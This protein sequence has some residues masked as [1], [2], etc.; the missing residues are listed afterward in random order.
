MI[1]EIRKR[2]NEKE[3]YSIEG[4]VKT[5]KELTNEKFR[6][7]KSYIKNL[8]IA[9]RDNP[10]D[11]TFEEIQF[12]RQINNKNKKGFNENKV[13]LVYK[14][15][16]VMLSRDTVASEILNKMPY[17]IRG[18]VDKLG[19]SINKQGCILYDDNRPIQTISDIMDFL[20][21]SRKIWNK[22][23]IYND[24]YCIIKKEKID[25]INYMVMNPLL[26]SSAYELSYFKFI[27]FGK[28]LRDGGYLDEYDYAFLCKIHQIVPE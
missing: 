20:D 6:D 21:I 28:T 8:E 4:N 18:M 27:V 12:L 5:L 25:G 24:E 17:D 14:N 9:F 11:L 22:F 26:F 3:Y 7:E 13:N 2:H 1:D 10:M 23:K 19:R 16:Y 15:G